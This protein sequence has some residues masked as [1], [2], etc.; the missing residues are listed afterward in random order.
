MFQ[1][2][3][4]NRIKIAA[5]KWGMTLTRYVM[6]CVGKQLEIEKKYE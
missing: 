2:E 1:K 3:F 5:I 6:G 4:Y